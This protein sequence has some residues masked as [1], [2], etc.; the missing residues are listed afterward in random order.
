MDM[1]SSLK[2]IE[3]LQRQISLLRNT[4]KQ[5]PKGFFWFDSSKKKAFEE[6]AADNEVA[7]AKLPKEIKVSPDVAEV[8]KNLYIDNLR[9]LKDI[10]G[11]LRAEDRALKTF[12]DMVS[13][14]FSPSP[15]TM[16]S[17]T[18]SLYDVHRAHSESEKALAEL[19]RKTDKSMKE[20]LGSYRLSQGNDGAFVLKR[21]SW[22][23]Y[24]VTEHT[25]GP[26]G[27]AHST[28]FYTAVHDVGIDD[29]LLP[30]D[31][32]QFKNSYNTNPSKSFNIGRW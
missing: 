22:F 14:I 13:A 32:Q 15:A 21:G 24:D 5:Q 2:D 12:T 30:A 8:L 28:A 31:L 20:I 1:I 17:L 9:A 11:N 18:H 27:G 6:V 3:S 4:L 23:V 16:L 10:N 19:A 29:S 7:Y 26:Q 25:S